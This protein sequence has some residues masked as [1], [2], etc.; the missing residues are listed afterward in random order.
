MKNPNIFN[1][2]TKSSVIIFLLIILSGK[3]N[4]V[5][6][7]SSTIGQVSNE[8]IYTNPEPD[9]SLQGQ[10][11]HLTQYI[12]GIFY[13]DV[14]QNGIDDFKF[15]VNG[16]GGLGGGATLCRV[17]PLNVENELLM[18]SET[19][20]GWP[21]GV[22]YTVNV[23]DTLNQDQV[24]DNSTVFTDSIGYLW[25]SL[26]NAASGPTVSMWNNIGEHF[27]GFRIK[28]NNDTL[29]GWIRIIVAVIHVESG[30][31]YTL[32]VKDYACN[33]NVFA[34]IP[35][36]QMPDYKIWPNPTSDYLNISNEFGNY[37]TGVNIYN[38]IGTKVEEFV[39]EKDITINISEYSPGVY[40][41]K[42]NNKPDVKKVVVY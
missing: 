19:S 3:D 13:I 30:W 36:L 32:T 37:E 27:I 38:S 22:F 40:Y 7:Q 35:K 6:P 17:F 42:F 29:Y 10:A 4:K 23:L 39:F 16:G 41:L 20:E 18:H 5:F 1:I 15:E 21:G 8:D 25:S 26:Y 28:P 9:S 31:I 24:I 14:D 2:F 33:I 11:A 34:A 12:G